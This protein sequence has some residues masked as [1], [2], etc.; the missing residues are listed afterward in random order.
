MKLA[1]HKDSAQ[2]AV[3]LIPV[4]PLPWSPDRVDNLF[5]YSHFVYPHLPYLLTQNSSVHLLNEKWQSKPQQSDILSRTCSW[6]DGVR[7]S[8]KNT[9]LQVG[10]V[11][12]KQLGPA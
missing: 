3:G 4:L 1:R 10:V 2:S 11:G 5:A 7:M 6:V 8:S 9:T 12:G